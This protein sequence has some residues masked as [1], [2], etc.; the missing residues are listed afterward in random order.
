MAVGLAAPSIP[1]GY[2]TTK[3]GGSFCQESGKR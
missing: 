3:E 1:N 2:Q